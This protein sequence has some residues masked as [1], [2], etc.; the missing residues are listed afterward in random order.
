LITLPPASLPKGATRLTVDALGSQIVTGRWESGA[1]L[2]HEQELAAMFG[3]GRN[4]LRE[5]V[6]VLAGKGL[7]STARRYGS[8]V[9]GKSEWNF[10]DADVLS[11]RLSEQ[12]GYARFL[13]D[14]TELRLC[15][16]PRAAMLA[17]LHATS[18]ERARLLAL[19]DALE[20]ADAPEAV[21]ID[22]EFHLGILEASHNE[23]MAGF[24]QPFRVLLRALFDASRTSLSGKYAY[25]SN[26]AIHRALAIAIRDGRPEEAYALVFA[27]QVRNHQGAADLAKDRGEW[28]IG[29]TREGPYPPALKAPS[30]GCVT[31]RSAKGH[32][33]MK[34][35]RR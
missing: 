21:M 28:W 25:D 17:A 13:R 22:T 20:K 3:V 4:V 2:P 12:G 10:F 5:A 35:G 9:R 19:I 34:K 7:I 26:P 24:R 18:E 6:K 23:L 27:M 15:I 14:L 11:W 29:P 8:R 33:K 30:R 16:E 31:R 1:K 32:G